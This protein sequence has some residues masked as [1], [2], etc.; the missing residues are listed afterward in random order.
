MSVLDWIPAGDQPAPD[1]ASASPQL[2]RRRT[3][4]TVIDLVIC[5][6]IIEAAIL[7]VLMVIFVDYFVAHP[8]ETIWLSVIGLIPIYL[9]YSLL[10]EWRF[11]RT[12]GKKR[13][14]LILSTPEGSYPTLVP[15]AI[16]NILRYIDW[17]PFG[18]LLGII[19][20]RR[21]ETGQRLGDKMA[22]TLVV[23]PETSAKP[24][25]SQTKTN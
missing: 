6:F 10:Y 20:I 19:L 24:R 22:N 16:R 17:L 3:M 18:Y 15:I 13:M 1:P 21:S 9:I 25:F 14:G 2:I 23:R 11:A 7:A 8:T 5:Y 12:P 4:A